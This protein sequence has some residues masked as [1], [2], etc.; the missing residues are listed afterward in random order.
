M[1]RREA[2]S[3]AVD[4]RPPRKKANRY[5]R[6]FDRGG[7]R[8][9]G[10]WERNGLYYTQIRISGRKVRLR[11][12][13]AETV[14]QAMEAMQ[15]LKKQRRAGTLKA[16][17]RKVSP[18][19]E[20]AQ[21][22]E[23]GAQAV[24]G[25]ESPLKDAVAGYKR[26][27]DAVESKDKKT[28]TRE[29]SGLNK[30]VE[31]FGVLPIDQI[32]T[33]TL[34][35]YAVW[36]KEDAKTRGRK[37]GGRTLDLDVLALRHVLEWA[38]VRKWLPKMPDLQWK[39]KAKAP[40]RD[41]L[42]SPEELDR[43]CDAAVLKP[44][45]LKLI[46][47]RFRHLREAQALTGQAFSDYMR[48]LAYS[49]GREQET[50]QLRWPNVHWKQ[51]CLH[52][53][54]ASQGGK[55]GGGSSEAGGPRDVDFHGKLETHLKAMYERRDPSTDLLFPSHRVE[56]SVQSFRKQLLRVQKETKIHDV[57]F[58]YFRHYFI[59]HCVMAGVDFMTIAKWVG[60]LDGGVL[61][62]KLYGHLS[63]EHPQAMAKK[64]DA[65]F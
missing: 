40:A 62:G 9:R 64:L 29:D 32:E 28:G 31:K 37:L 13:H 16:P 8:V 6:V 2:Q 38:V 39:K 57:T 41:R 54:G 4:V 48:L 23:G 52:F 26:N 61:I 21:G 22:V 20:G 17:R 1:K 58:Q 63:R 7:E 56:G 60:H 42:I 24:G 3:I 19:P 45:A 11:L 18:M 50:L 10:L 5:N 36:R 65:K 44:E 34:D 59:S 25:P 33:G 35:D 55:R 43:L 12:E 46:N 30:W 47:P 53:P 14:P 49:G 51:R 15:A 27:R